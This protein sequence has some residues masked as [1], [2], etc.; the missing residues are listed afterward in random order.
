MTKIGKLITKSSDQKTV[1][2]ISNISK[3]LTSNIISC[4]KITPKILTLLMKKNYISIK[5]LLF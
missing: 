3:I 2:L 5:L 4:K 1:S